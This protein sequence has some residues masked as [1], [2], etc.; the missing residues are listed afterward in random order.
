MSHRQSNYHCRARNRVQGRA[1]TG[2]LLIGIIRFCSCHV[3]AWD[4]DLS[5]CRLL[6]ERLHLLKVVCGLKW[7]PSI[8]LFWVLWL[9]VV[10]SSCFAMCFPPAFCTPTTCLWAFVFVASGVQVRSGCWGSIGSSLRVSSGGGAPSTL[11]MSRSLIDSF[12][13]AIQVYLLYSNHDG[14]GWGRPV[15]G[16][17]LLG[18]SS[19]FIDIGWYCW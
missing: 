14:T 4:V 6:A 19:S 3:H 11:S 5:M 8:P 2:H 12:L 16:R 10:Q 18:N 17:I 7:M 13:M 9:L 15:G 1:C